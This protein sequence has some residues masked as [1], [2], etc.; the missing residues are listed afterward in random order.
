MGYRPQSQKSKTVEEDLQLE[1]DLLIE[2]SE[3]PGDS[4]AGPLQVTQ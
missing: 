2:I 4:S 1:Q 3:S